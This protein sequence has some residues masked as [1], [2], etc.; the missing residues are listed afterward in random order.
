MKWITASYLDHFV[1]SSNCIVTFGHNKKELY[2]IFVYS[3][4]PKCY[5]DVILCVFT[6]TKWFKRW[7]TIKKRNVLSS[8]SSKSGKFLQNNPDVIFLNVSSHLRKKN[9]PD[10]DCFQILSWSY[11]FFPILIIEHLPSKLLDNYNA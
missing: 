11:L 10:D 2:L 1:L 8:F 5:V 7:L 6:E 9:N 4:V 3:N